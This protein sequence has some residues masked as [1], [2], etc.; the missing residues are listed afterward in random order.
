[1]DG[2]PVGPYDLPR[3]DVDP[4]D[5]P[6]IADMVHGADALGNAYGSI[7]HAVTE[8]MVAPQI[9]L[10]QAQLAIGQQIQTALSQVGQQYAGADNAAQS[11]IEASL[12]Q[13][14]GAAA[15][16][17]IP[18][19]QPQAIAQQITG[20]PPFPPSLGLPDPAYQVGNWTGFKVVYGEPREL[21]GN[22][23]CG[24]FYHAIEDG[25][26]GWIV[27]LTGGTPCPPLHPGGGFPGPHCI[28]CGDALA[29]Q[30]G[31]LALGQDIFL[32][33]GCACPPGYAPRPGQW[34]HDFG[35]GCG[36]VQVQLCS[37]PPGAPPP[38]VIP[39]PPAPAPP[40]P[41][42]PAP[43][44]PPAAPCPPLKLWSGS[45]CYIAPAEDPP[46]DPQ[47]VLLAEGT[48]N[49]SW[50]ALIVQHC[51][52]PCPAEPQPQPG[53]QPL[54]EASCLGDLPARVF[55]EQELVQLIL[56][57][58]PALANA[59]QQGI[60]GL[61]A[62]ILSKIGIT[63]PT[64][65][66]ALELT[67][68][69]L[70]G[71]VDALIAGLSCGG[72]GSVPINTTLAALSLL[73][74]YLI[75]LPPAVTRPLEQERDFRCPTELPSPSQAS[76]AWL[77]NTIDDE[78]W[79]CW[80]RAG[81]FKD[82][83]AE[84]VRHAGRSK[85][86]PGEIMGL[87]HRGIFTPQDVVEKIRELGFTGDQ[88]AIQLERLSQQ[89][90][91]LQ[92]ILRFMVRDAGDDGLAAKFGMD[93]EFTVKYSAQLKQWSDDQGIIPEYA[94]YAWRSHWD[95]PSPTQLYEMY[96][97][98]R[99]DWIDPAD[100]VTLD[101]V[102]TALTQDDK[103]PYWIPKY[104]AISFLPLGR[105]DIRRAYQIGVLSEEEMR[106]HY[107]AIGY[108]DDDAQL[109]TN[110]T[111]KTVEEAF[112]NSTVVGK[113]VSYKI[114]REEAVDRLT[115][116]GAG[117]GAINRV[118]D[119][120]VKGRKQA[121]RAKCQAALKK[122]YFRYEFTTS[123][124]RSELIQGGAEL[125]EADNL[126]TGWECE[127][128]SRGKVLPAS[129]VCG[130]FERGLLGLSDLYGRFLAIGYSPQDAAL[131]TQ[132]CAQRVGLKIDAANRKRMEQELAAAQKQAKLQTKANKDWEKLID[133]LGRKDQKLRDQLDKK[134]A[135]AVRMREQQEKLEA[136]RSKQLM[137][138]AEKLV[139]RS[140]QELSEVYH[141][142]RA[143]IYQAVPVW[144]SNL[145][146]AVDAATIAS[147]D[148][149]AVDYAAWLAIWQQLGAEAALPVPADLPPT[150]EQ[151]VDRSI[152]YAEYPP[153][154]TLP[155]EPFPA[156][157]PGPDSGGDSI[158]KPPGP[159]TGNTGPSPPEAASPAATRQHA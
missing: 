33:L 110:Y 104:L 143:V 142:M 122:R 100:R 93:D 144:W 145:T 27:M 8:S 158:T 35:D 112:V 48:P 138:A 23:A 12:A 136:Q 63:A 78:T 157:A 44:C 123:Q 15:N 133:D 52:T 140:G 79:R 134:R 126:A 99:H 42:P 137:T 22:D 55:Q 70:F 60:G 20:L 132:D 73:Q 115:Q 51:G 156:P 57:I 21:L 130:L 95:I 147:Q 31:A 41:P 124:V 37:L 74:K 43:P 139:E 7:A 125:E 82:P 96:H 59:P 18:A 86:T 10:G 84:R 58:F 29:A 36:V 152:P 97:R 17:G 103:L 108:S 81:G 6:W 1:M 45:E 19:L 159:P 77:A 89:I 68:Q 67:I 39:P 38:I 16:T 13:A 75:D 14:Y 131:M 4:L 150:L 141:S 85:L 32:P 109:L 120:I 80:T 121:V 34:Q 3:L 46:R 61:L 65:A 26:G 9:A 92:D 101:D 5:P 69:T 102:K 98:L 155:A 128:S 94:K 62:L 151:S 127:R 148:A 90:P 66:Q 105:I 56:S 91:T 72:P 114:S 135:A 118:E 129:T 117:Q 106:R 83:E 24:G 2:T 54:A 111:V 146:K 153:A 71:P 88:E 154:T 50:I 113:A 107:L 64:L 76:M 25:H 119:R 116:A 87:F 30:Q 49:T 11:A 40:G 53:M 47:D 28:T 149:E